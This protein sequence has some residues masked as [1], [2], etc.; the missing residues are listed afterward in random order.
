M[1]EAQPVVQIDGGRGHGLASDRLQHSLDRERRHAR[2]DEEL[3]QHLGGRAIVLVG[4]PHSLEQGD[5]LLG[6]ARFGGGL[7]ALEGEPGPTV[8]LGGLQVVADLLVELGRGLEIPAELVGV[9]R[10]VLEPGPH[11]DRARGRVAVSGFVG[12]GGLREHPH[13][14]VQLG[15]PEEVAALDEEGRRLRRLV[16]LECHLASKVRGLDD[17]AGLRVG[18]GGLGVVLRPHVHLGRLG[19]LAELG[20]SA[21]RR[22]EVASAGID[23]MG[24]M[25]VPG[26]LEE[27]AGAERA[28]LVARLRRRGVARGVGHVFREMLLESLGRL[29]EFALFLEGLRGLQRIAAL[30]IELGRLVPLPGQAKEPCGFQAVALLQEEDGGFAGLADLDQEG[31]RLLVVARLKVELGRLLAPAHLFVGGGG[32]HVLLAFEVG[33]G[34]LGKHVGLFEHPAGGQPVFPFL[35][36]PH[37]AVALARGVAGAQD[38]PNDVVAGGPSSG[39]VDLDPVRE[40]LVGEKETD[41]CDAVE[42]VGA[43]ENEVEQIH[44]ARQ[45]SRAAA[46]QDGRL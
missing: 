20:E 4:R 17:V 5:G 27:P 12:R 29:Q 15:R 31:G 13:G 45:P 42:D 21:R 16:G 9:G 3:G 8:E 2:L 33:L 46:L 22:L 24:A 35:E 11:V 25:Q 41:Y 28:L 1:G 32:G 14:F 40:L 36:L 44:E 39:N 10:S 34:R 38:L 37:G 19:V 30:R 6:V 7:A 26:L 18:L 23:L 43:V